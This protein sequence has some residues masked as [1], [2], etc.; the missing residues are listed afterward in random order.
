MD[1]ALS[2]VGLGA[3]A[4]YHENDP[5]LWNGPT[6][7]YITDYRAPMSPTDSKTWSPIYLWANPDAYEPN[8]MAISFEPASDAKPPDDRLYTLELLYVPEGVEGAPPVGTVWEVPA[9]LPFYI[10]VPT[11]KTYDWS[12]GYR[13]AFKVWPAA[14]A[15]D[16][17]GP[18]G[19]P[20]GFTDLSDLAALLGSYGLCTGDPGFLPEADLT[21]GSE[22]EPDGCVTLAD[23]AMLLGDYGC[24]TTP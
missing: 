19:T 12:A 24:R 17:T 21:G 1:R 2:I 3:A 22:G 4:I 5:N 7:Y 11:Y 18:G 8:T 6:D 23:L 20:D 16:I 9:D 10:E 14:C 13:F 15:G